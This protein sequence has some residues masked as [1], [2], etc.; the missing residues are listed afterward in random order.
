MEWLIILVIFV[1]IY[2]ICCLAE[3]IKQQEEQIDT[4]HLECESY[5]Q[6][7]VN[8]NLIPH[9]IAESK[10]KQMNDKYG[11]IKLRIK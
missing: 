7:L 8:E 4:L 1:M 9:N 11:Q 3:L 2:V 5:L 10:I 6:T